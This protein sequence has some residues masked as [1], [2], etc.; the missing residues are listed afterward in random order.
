MRSSPI[1]L[2]IGLFKYYSSI[3][4]VY[5][6]NGEVVL[7]NIDYLPCALSPVLLVSIHPIQISDHLGTHHCSCLDPCCLLCRLHRYLTTRL[8]Q[9][10]RRLLDLVC[11]HY[12]SPNL[13]CL[14]YRLHRCLT[15]P[16]I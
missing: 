1:V 11:H 3:W 9:M 6:Y 4:T 15:L 8:D 7:I 10:G 2:V 5:R 14:L 16:W 13:H 12:L